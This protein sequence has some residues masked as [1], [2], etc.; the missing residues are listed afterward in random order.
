[1]SMRNIW[2]CGK[3]LRQF[4]LQLSQYKLSIKINVL[5]NVS[6]CFQSVGSNLDADSGNSHWL[7][8]THV[9]VKQAPLPKRDYL[10]CGEKGYS[11]MPHAILHGVCYLA[12]SFDN[13]VTDS[14][15]LQKLH[16]QVSHYTLSITMN[17]LRNISLC[18]R[19]VGSS[20]DADLGNRNCL[21]V[22]HVVFRQALLPERDCL[23]CD[24]NAY[25][26]VPHSFLQSVCYLTYAFDNSI[27]NSRVLQKFNLQ[28]LF[29]AEL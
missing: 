6:L 28:V 1:M 5:R 13:R 14:R 15:V 9:V 17:V 24:D 20:L 27:T 16:L 22:T 2:L 4:N 10:V 21:W 23:V 8:V 7:W 3:V 11:C 25:S 12:Y 18:L 19:N 29:I 26:C